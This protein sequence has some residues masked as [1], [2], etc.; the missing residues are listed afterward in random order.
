MRSFLKNLSRVLAVGIS[1]VGSSAAFACPSGS[2]DLICPDDKVYPESYRDGYATVIAVSPNTGIVTV[3]GNYSSSDDRYTVNDLAV[4]TGCLGNF[5]VG[6]GKG[7]QVIPESYNDGYATVI[8]VNPHS[9]KLTVK[10]NYSSSYERYTP[11]QIAK[12]SG[13]M[14][15]ICVGDKVFPDTYSNGYAIVKAI[16]PATKLFT[17]KGNHGSSYGRYQSYQ[18]SVIEECPDY[19]HERY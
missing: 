18:L 16:N 5:C 7:E 12:Q 9:G 6:E 19:D 2:A 3:N 11:D 15:R 10:G 17:V 8:A 13:C 14:E 1:F 4:A